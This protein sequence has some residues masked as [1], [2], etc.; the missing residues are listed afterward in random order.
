VL[1]DIIEVTTKL[2]EFIGNFE[3]ADIKKRESIAEYFA[4]ISASL[5]EVS[6]Q[7]EK[8]DLPYDKIAELKDLAEGLPSAIGKEIGQDEAIQLSELLRKSVDGSFDDLHNRKDAVRLIKESAGKFDSLAFR[9][10][11]FDSKS[12]SFSGSPKVVALVSLTLVGIVVWFLSQSDLFHQDRATSISAPTSPSPQTLPSSPPFEH[13]S[14]NLSSIFIEN[15]D[16]LAINGTS[17]IAVVDIQH[18]ANCEASYNW[19]FKSSEANSLEE[20]GSGELYEQYG[21]TGVKNEVTDVGGSLYINAGSYSIQ[22][23][24]R[25]EDSGWVYNDDPSIEISKLSSIKLEDFRL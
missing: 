4:R 9:V 20:N 15:S 11:Y 8:R 14:S 19:R 22:W 17:G 23:S 6:E 18:R 12:K 7:L 1:S 5:K 10:K 3:Q 25:S 24:C 21:S 2:V 16:L 13:S